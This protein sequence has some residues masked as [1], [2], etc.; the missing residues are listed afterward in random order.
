VKVEIYCNWQFNQTCGN[1][2]RLMGVMGD[3]F[4]EQQA[5]GKRNF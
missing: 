1:K 5:K 4:G 2:C 3:I